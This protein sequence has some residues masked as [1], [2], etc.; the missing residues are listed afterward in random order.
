MIK[1][2]LRGLN[3]TSE[4]FNSINIILN[5]ALDKAKQITIKELESNLSSKGFKAKVVVEN[6]ENAAP[7]IFNQGETVVNI[8]NKATEATSVS[9]IAINLLVEDKKKIM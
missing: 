6:V 2:K 8:I 4:Y 1:Y 3:S 9:E 7:S 5:K